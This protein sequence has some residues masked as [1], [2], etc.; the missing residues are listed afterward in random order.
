VISRLR[1]SN[2]V[3][4][5]AM[6]LVENQDCEYVLGGQTDHAPYWWIVDEYMEHWWVMTGRGSL[7][8]ATRRKKVL[9]YC[10]AEESI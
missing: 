2:A 3:Q 6:S 5:T 1:S 4:S 9:L 10:C 7:K 8:H